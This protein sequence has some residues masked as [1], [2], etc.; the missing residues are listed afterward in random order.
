MH[1]VI[2]VREH[3]APRGPE[4]GTAIADAH[5]LRCG[6]CDVTWRGTTG[7]ACWVCGD[8][9]MPRGDVRIVEDEPAA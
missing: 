9:G 7:D 3:T 2:R 6:R 8:P 5:P 4:A 1:R